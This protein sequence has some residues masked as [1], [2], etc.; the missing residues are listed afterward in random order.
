VRAEIIRNQLN[1]K[2]LQ[3]A[4][5]TMEVDVYLLKTLMREA[6]DILVN[7]CP[8]SEADHGKHQS[9]HPAGRPKEDDDFDD[10]NSNNNTN[11][12]HDPVLE[13]RTTSVRTGPTVFITDNM[14]KKTQDRALTDKSRNTT[15]TPT[16]NG[17]KSCSSGTV[18]SCSDH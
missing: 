15:M 9:S 7:K 10:D 17:P 11:N 18:P 8:H 2:R 1:L 3:A 6:R 12:H 4:N 16:S 13:R 14:H 5:L